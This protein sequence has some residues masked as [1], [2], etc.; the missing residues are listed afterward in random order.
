MINIELTNKEEHSRLI[1]NQNPNIF[2]FIWSKHEQEHHPDKDIDAYEF[3]KIEEVKAK[4]EI[5]VRPF[6]SYTSIIPAYYF[7]LSSF[8]YSVSH[9]VSKY[10]KHKK[11]IYQD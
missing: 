10:S 6:F 4:H 8:C 9:M 2:L 1:I 7:N 5:Y 3:K 11:K